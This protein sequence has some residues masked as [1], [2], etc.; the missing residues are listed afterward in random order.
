MDI[1]E[2]RLLLTCIVAKHGSTLTVKTGLD[3]YVAI[4]ENLD[5]GI[6]VECYQFGDDATPVLATSFTGVSVLNVVG[7][8]LPNDIY[9]ELNGDKSY[10]ANINTLG[11]DDIVE[12]VLNEVTAKNTLHINTSTGN[13]YVS[14]RAAWLVDAA[15][16]VTI[17]TGSGDDVAAIDCPYGDIT[18]AAK[19]SLSLSL[20][21]GNDDAS[22]F[23]WPTTHF[24]QKPLIRVSGGSGQ[25]ALSVDNDLWW[26]SRNTLS[27]VESPFAVIPCD[28]ENPLYPCDGVLDGY[29]VRLK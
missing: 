21:S 2:P 5:S 24:N 1:L 11:G 28:D 13:D 16:N 9:V 27:T 4:V 12:V 26:V 15:L 7:N 10:I 8:P 29:F 18:P 17:N 14:V 20:G 23:L 3:E 19:L 25:D 6:D 22:I